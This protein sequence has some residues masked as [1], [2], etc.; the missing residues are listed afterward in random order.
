MRA[1][2][3]VLRTRC[4]REVERAGGDERILVEHLVEVAHP[5][6]D[7]GITVLTLGVEVLTHRGSARMRDVCIE[8]LTH[9]YLSARMLILRLTRPRARGAARCCDDGRVIR[10]QASDASRAQA[11]RLPGELVALLEQEA[12]ALQRG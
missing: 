11:E 7:D 5:E 4:Q 1:A 6:E 3:G 9:Y 2:V 10:E 8:G 12:I